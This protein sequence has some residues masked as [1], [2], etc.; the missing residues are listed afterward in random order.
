MTRKARKFLGPALAAVLVCAGQAGP[1]LSLSLPASPYYETT[2][3][4]IDGFPV[5]ET[6]T[7]VFQVL[8][9]IQEHY[10]DPIDLADLV[11][12]GLESLTHIDP[13]IAIEYDSQRFMIWRQGRFIRNFK[14]PIGS[15]AAAWTHL[16][17][18]SLLAL[19][20]KSERIA[21]L[22]P[23]P[24]RQSLLDGLA[25]ALDRN[26]RYATPAETEEASAIREGFGGVG[27]RYRL[28]QDSMEILN[29]TLGS[30][31]DR[32]GLSPGDAITHLDGLPVREMGRENILRMLRGPINSRLLVTMMRTDHAHPV[33]L[34]LTR[35]HLAAMT[36]QAEVLDSALIVSIAEFNQDTARSVAGEI[37]WA[38]SK[39]AE[40]LK[41]IILDL[42]GNNGGS[43]D[44]AIA[45]A[46]LFLENGVLSDIRGRSPEMTEV[47]E[48]TRNNP[49]GDLPTVVLIDGHTASAAEIVASALQDHGRAV[50]IGSNSWGKGTVQT[51]QKLPNH[52]EFV[53]TSARL[54][55]P[56]GY[57]LHDLGV[58]PALC[59]S[60]DA[61][62]SAAYVTRFETGGFDRVR[63]D[64]ADWRNTDPANTGLTL[65]MR[66]LCPRKSL[67]GDPFEIEFAQ[68][69]LARPALVERALALTTPPGLGHRKSDRGMAFR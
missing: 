29:V 33:N 25:A 52:G 46:D 23:Q 45:V 24:L 10:V 21:A 63:D 58:L 3:G 54:Y 17:V 65:E 43:L 6:E 20:R 34:G 57:P 42:R 55:T 66:A 30:P 2:E 27:L 60:A 22:Q 36:V 28:V 68:D 44:D 5:T 32:A 1:A 35:E 59:T 49:A 9:T 8:S 38:R 47:L 62:I 41:G 51:A 16:T 7:L 14:N 13:D 26:S 12:A 19:R 53:Y 4:S 64:M 37:L 18:E 56:S 69:I 67:H 48:A 40:R 61:K 31:A 50:V 15:D 39:I 11:K